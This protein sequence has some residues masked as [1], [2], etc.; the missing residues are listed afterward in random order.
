[1]KKAEQAD[2][3]AEDER[4]RAEDER[5]RAEQADKRAEYLA[6]KLRELGINP[7]QLWVIL[8]FVDSNNWVIPESKIYFG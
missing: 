8:Y 7:N 1:M 5:Q 4:Q 3:R 2:K 6:A